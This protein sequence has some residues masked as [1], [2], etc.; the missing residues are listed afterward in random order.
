MSTDD[1][2]IISTVALL[3]LLFVVAIVSEIM[4]AGA[5][6]EPND[7]SDI[8]DDELRKKLI[9]LDNEEAWL[10]ERTETIDASDDVALE[11]QRRRIEL[12]EEAGYMP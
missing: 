7:Y 8:D 5:T 3:V 2:F 1:I 6:A 12:L 4:S 10:Q 11:Y 9:E